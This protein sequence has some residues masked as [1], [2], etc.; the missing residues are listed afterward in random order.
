MSKAHFDHVRI[1][2][3]YQKELK[4]IRENANRDEGGKAKSINKTCNRDKRERALT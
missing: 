3:R 4:S 1:F 2:L